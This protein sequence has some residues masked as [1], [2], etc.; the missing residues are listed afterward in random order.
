M[1]PLAG[2]WCR[3]GLRLQPDQLDRV[4]LSN[5]DGKR[6]PLTEVTRIVLEPE[7]API[8]RKDNER[9]I[10]VGGEQLVG[11]RLQRRARPG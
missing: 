1:V 6:V 10:Y 11:D 3:G 7:T 5:S 2:S 9:V 4:Y 8:Q